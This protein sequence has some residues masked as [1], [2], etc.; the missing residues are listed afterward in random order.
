V[1]EAVGVEGDV[2]EREVVRVFGPAQGSLVETVEGQQL[3]HGI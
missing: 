1:R 3:T 2:V